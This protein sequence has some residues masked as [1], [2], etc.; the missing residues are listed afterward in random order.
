MTVKIM[1]KI[2]YSTLCVIALAACNDGSSNKS[3]SDD[4]A[5]NP[6][7]DR[8]F[9]ANQN[10]EPTAL[11]A[12]ELSTELTRIFGGPNDEP[13]SIEAGDTLADVQARAES[14]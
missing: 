4:T 3:S 6:N 9:S 2:A 5:Q 1:T 8:L 10:D 7:V 13:V 11:D 12:N 14:N